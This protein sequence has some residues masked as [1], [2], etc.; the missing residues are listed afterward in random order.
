MTSVNRFRTVAA[1]VATA[2]ALM[3]AACGSDSKS[4]STTAPPA[5]TAA[6]GATTTGAAA[7]TAAPATTA[8]GATTT[9]ADGAAG[10]P[11]GADAISIKDFKFGPADLKVAVGATVTWT[12]DDAQPHTATSAGNFDTGAIQPGESKTATFPTAGTFSY[13]CSFHPFMNG[14]I[15]VG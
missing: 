12:N 1:V 13:I 8:G 2:G 9:A 5:T 11:A 10:A 7:T 3:L 14:T 15:T 4:S 6:A